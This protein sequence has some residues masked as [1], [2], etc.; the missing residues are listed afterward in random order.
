MSDIISFIAKVK[1]LFQAYG[2]R[3]AAAV[4]LG[5]T[6]AALSFQDELL[7]ERVIISQADARNYVPIQYGDSLDGGTSTAEA[8]PGEVMS[9]TCTLRHT[10]TSPFCGVG[11]RLSEGRADKGMALGNFETMRIKLGYA[12]PSHLLRIHLKSFDRRFSR[13]GQ[14]NTEKYNYADV[15]V[16]NGQQMLVIDLRTFAVAEWWKTMMNL[17]PK[18]A[19]RDLSNIVG[20]EI[21]TGTDGR[22]GNYEIQID[23][24]AFERP[25]IASRMLY[26]VIGGIWV[27][28]GG[29]VLVRRRHKS[30][31]VRDREALQHKWAS[32]HDELTGLPNRRLFQARL[33]QECKRAQAN[34]STLGLLLLD[35]DHFKDVNDTLGHQAGDTLLKIVSDRLQLSVREND[36]VGRIGGDEFAI[37][38]NEVSGGDELIRIGNQVLERMLVPVRLVEQMVSPGGSI[39]GALQPDHATNANDLFK[40]ADTALYSLKS[41]GRGGTKLFH[42]YMMEQAEAAAT[43]LGQARTAVNDQSIVPHYQP[44]VDLKDGER[45]G[46]EALFR[47]V[48]ERGLQMPSSVERAFNDYELAAKIGE[49]MQRAVARDLAFWTAQGLNAGCVSLNA[50]PA[51]FL[52]DDYAERLLRVLEEECVSPNR[53]EVEVTEHVFFDR[54]GDQVS[55]A[56]QLLRKHGVRISLDDFGTGY[57]SL[58]HLRD[59]RV[60]CVK[61]DRSFVDKLHSDREIAAIVSAIT[62]LSNTL[63]MDVVAEGIETQAQA[64]TLRAMGCGMGQGYLYGKPMSADDV[65]ILLRNS[66]PRRHLRVV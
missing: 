8:V 55:R 20:F 61:I 50:S 63:G 53:I 57:S 1:K 21:Q 7:T 64:D 48:S 25:I 24:I 2:V 3:F 18:L 11:L 41:S 22:A 17:P 43:Q 47:C 10:G 39:G 56:V 12:G 14:P 46:F 32:E 28:L 34:G 45:V 5:A 19:A 40:A 15:N 27:L 54:S 66:L 51:E 30:L 16:K 4:A 65:G 49:Q 44:K 23:E 52:R 31:L 35:L 60:D 9:W 6:V 36:F 26:T 37:I 33:K 62:A 13:A 38:L 59:I 29:M 42:P 58:S